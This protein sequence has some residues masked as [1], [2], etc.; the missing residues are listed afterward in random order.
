MKW[1]EIKDFNEIL[2]Y[3][4]TLSSSVS[5]NVHQYFPSDFTKWT[6]RVQS[7]YPFLTEYFDSEVFKEKS[8]EIDKVLARALNVAKK[9]IAKRSQ[10]HIKLANTLK[11]IADQI[12]KGDNQ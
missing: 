1:K 8:G 5:I 7:T 4:A 9:I 2:H 10:K 6:V 11:E 12:G 3:Q